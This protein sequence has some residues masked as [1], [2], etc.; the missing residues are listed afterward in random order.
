MSAD[1]PAS[2]T[3]ERIVEWTIESQRQYAD[4]FND[5]DVDVIFE[6]DGQSWRIPTFWREEGTR[7]PRQF[8]RSG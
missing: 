7:F 1:A 8:S 5:V 2:G 4:P 6:K 3:H